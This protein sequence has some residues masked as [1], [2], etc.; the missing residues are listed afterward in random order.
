MGKQSRQEHSPIECIFYRLPNKNKMSLTEECMAVYNNIRE[1]KSLRYAIFTIEE[2]RFVV[3]TTRDLNGPRSTYADFRAHITQNQWPKY[4]LFMY[5][6]QPEGAGTTI[7]SKLLLISWIPHGG[8]YEKKMFYKSNFERLKEA[9]VGVD[10][11][12]AAHDPDDLEQGEV[13]AKI[14]R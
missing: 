10:M 9:F 14:L 4:G 2:G 12:I 13:E 3:E 11:V 7:M 8:S 1:S 5:T 6:F